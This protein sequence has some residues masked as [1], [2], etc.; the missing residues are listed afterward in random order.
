VRNPRETMR[1]VSSRTRTGVK[2]I[3]HYIPRFAYIRG[4]PPGR[5]LTSAKSSMFKNGTSAA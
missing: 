1:A 2:N 5:S 3:G 4:M